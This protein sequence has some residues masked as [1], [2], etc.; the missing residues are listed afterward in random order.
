MFEFHIPS[1]YFVPPIVDFVFESGNITWRRKLAC[2]LIILQPKV[3]QDGVIHKHANTNYIW[4]INRKQCT[5]LPI[6]RAKNLFDLIPVWVGEQLSKVEWLR[7]I[8]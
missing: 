2:S 3:L 6:M 8:K 5:V 4:Q 7:V 1:V